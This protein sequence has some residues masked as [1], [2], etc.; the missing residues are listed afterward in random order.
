MANK[1]AGIDVLVKI[2]TSPIGGQTGASLSRSADTIET[3]DKSATGK[4]RSYIAGFKEWSVDCDAFVVLN[5]TAQDAIETAFNDGSEV[6]VE[7]IVGDS[8]YSG[9]ALVTDL[10]MEFSMDDAVTYSLSLQGTGELTV[11]AVA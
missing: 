6:T 7:L 5:D 1:I 9:N 4:F 11:S 8:K 2:G 10:S 3:T